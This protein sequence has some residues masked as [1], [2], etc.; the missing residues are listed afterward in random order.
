MQDTGPS[1][2]SLDTPGMDST[3][4]LLDHYLKTLRNYSELKIIGL[5]EFY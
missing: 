3:P 1:E 4:L 5:N 2:P